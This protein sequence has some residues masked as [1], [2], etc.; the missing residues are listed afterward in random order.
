MGMPGQLNCGS[1]DD[2]TDEQLRKSIIHRLTKLT[3]ELFG[4][5]NKKRGN[6]K[7]HFER[8]IRL[9]IGIRRLEMRREGK[10]IGSAREPMGFFGSFHRAGRIGSSRM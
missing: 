4:G 6:G 2:L 8:A 3:I 5:R 7:T 9:I 1:H 10:W